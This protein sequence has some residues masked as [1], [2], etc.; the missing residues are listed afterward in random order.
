MRGLAR[1]ASLFP[2]LV[3]EG[4]VQMTEADVGGP[5]AKLLTLF[6]FETPHDENLALISYH[7]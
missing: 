7:R 4:A 3:P 5:Q 6:F 1:S 2:L